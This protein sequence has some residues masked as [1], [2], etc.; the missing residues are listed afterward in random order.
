MVR[1]LTEGTFSTG[2]IGLARILKIQMMFYNYHEN[3]R[4]A[5]P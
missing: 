3:A 5:G 2:R 4:R 1:G